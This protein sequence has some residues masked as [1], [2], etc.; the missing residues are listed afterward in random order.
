MR[1]PVPTVGCA[2]SRSLLKDLDPPINPEKEIDDPEDKKP[3]DWVDEAEIDDPDATKPAG[4]NARASDEV[5]AWVGGW[6]CTE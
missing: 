4:Q 2:A 3:A 5:C 6:F 1:C